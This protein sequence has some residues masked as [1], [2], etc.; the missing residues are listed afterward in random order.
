MSCD[1]SR[2]GECD[3]IAAEE[4]HCDDCSDFIA[5]AQGAITGGGF[6]LVYSSPNKAAVYNRNGY[7]LMEIDNGM[8]RKKGNIGSS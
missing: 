4:Y 7:L 1:I 8:F 5:L 2:T 6:V 3:R